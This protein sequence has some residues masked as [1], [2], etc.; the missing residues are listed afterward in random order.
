[1]YVKASWKKRN[2]IRL[3]DFANSGI[4]G[5]MSKE[6][7]ESFIVLTITNVSYQSL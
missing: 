6:Q 5:E 2:S 3:W 4:D 7:P 1:M